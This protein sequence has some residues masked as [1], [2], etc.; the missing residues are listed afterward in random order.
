MIRLTF[1]THAEVVIDPD[2]PVPDWGLSARGRARHQ[3]FAETLKAGGSKPDTI[4]SSAERKAREAAEITA[5]VLGVPTRQL[6]ALHENDRSAT[7]FIPEPGFSTAVRAFFGQPDESYKG[8]E[9]ASAAQARIVA[10]THH[11][12]N[13]TTRPHTMIVAHGGV[14]ALLMAHAAGEEISMAFSQCATGGGSA[15]ELAAWPL[16]MLEGWRDIAPD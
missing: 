12:L 9:T 10:A 14:G 16:R 1:V 3:V 6:A 5:D 2:T 13:E 11:I 7:G 4:W 15:F 8:W